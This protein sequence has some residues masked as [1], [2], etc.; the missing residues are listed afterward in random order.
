MQWEVLGVYDLPHLLA[1]GEGHEHVVQGR[2]LCSTD[3]VRFR[4]TVTAHPEEDTGRLIL[5]L[6]RVTEGLVHR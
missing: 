3:D 2:N 4:A 6:R 5:V 1:T